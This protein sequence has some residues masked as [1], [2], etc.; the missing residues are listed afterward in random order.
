MSNKIITFGWTDVKSN[1]QTKK[2]TRTHIHSHLM[3][4]LANEKNISFISHENLYKR[5]DYL[6]DSV[7]LSGEQVSSQATLEDIYTTSSGTRPL[8]HGINV[9]ISLQNKTNGEANSNIKHGHMAGQISTSI[10]GLSQR[11]KITSL[12]ECL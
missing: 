7:H 11:F 5:S 2:N 12:Q 4:K 1:K 10:N 6:R 9:I 3:S 8:I